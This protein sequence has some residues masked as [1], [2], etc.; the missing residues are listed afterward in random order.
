VDAVIV[1]APGLPW[2]EP[3]FATLQQAVRDD[4][5]ALA[6]QALDTAADILAAE[7]RVRRRLG[8]LTAESAQPVVADAEAHL[9]RLLRPGFVVSAGAGRLPD[10]LRY[11]RG[12]E[13]RL[14]RLDVARDAR[15][16]ADVRPLEQRW[17]A[18]ARRSAPGR[19]PPDVVEL[20]W[21][22]EE[23]RISVFAQPLGTHTSVSPTRLRKLLD[24]LDS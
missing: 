12:I 19:V 24:D 14:E 7:T 9:G 6:R 10:V 20:G 22:L 1:E 8:E 21:L 18:I 15:R 11:V 2:D 5:L 17:E 3:A 16:R 13:H 4:A 23:L